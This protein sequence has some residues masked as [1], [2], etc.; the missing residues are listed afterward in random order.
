[1][2]AAEEIVTQLQ[3]EKIEIDDVVVATV[4]LQ[5]QD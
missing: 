5:W 1:M 4:V 2:L 3:Q